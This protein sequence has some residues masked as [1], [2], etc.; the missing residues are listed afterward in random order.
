MAYKER[1]YAFRYAVEVEQYHSARHRPPGQER[2]PR[3]KPTPEQ[4]RRNNQREK[5]KKCRHRLRGHFDVDDYFVTLTYRR[6]G[7]PEGMDQAK[8]HFRKFARKL[9]REYRKRGQELKWIRN[10]EVGSRGAWHVH[11]AVNRIPDGDILIR[12]AWKHGSVQLQLMDDRNEFRELASYLTKTPDTD[13]RLADTNYS[14]SRNLPLKEPEEKIVH[15]KTWRKIRIPE[16]WYLDKGSF[17]EGIN[18]V[19]GYPFRKY[20]I[21]RKRE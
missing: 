15:W 4:V 8:D 21:L 16:G 14:T 17:A 18:P 6:E 5:E 10:I 12:K 3:K 11:V 13:P 19:T 1:K 7:R 20:T 2:E 9:Q